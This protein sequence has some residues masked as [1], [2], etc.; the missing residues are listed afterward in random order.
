M[1]I[2]K[3]D[4]VSKS[5]GANL[6]L[7]DI[8]WQVSAND[9]VGLIGNNGTGKTTLFKIMTGE[10]S[11]YKGTVERTKRA[12]VGYLS[13][14][15]E[16]DS[17]MKLR[18]AVRMAAFEHMHD[19]E[20]RMELLTQR[21]GDPEEEDQTAILDQ[22]ARLQERH[23][24]YGG[25]NYEHRMDS[26]LGGLGF[27]QADFQL[28]VG[29]LSGGQRGRAALAHLLLLEPD[30][31]LLDEPTNH[32]D[33]AGTEWL[34]GFIASEYKGAVVVVSHDRYF[35]DKVVTKVVELQNHRLEEYGGNYTKYLF[36]K[37]RKL[38][39]QQR[40]YVRQQEEIA[41]DEEFI[42]RY[43]AGQRTKEARGREKKLARMELVEKPQLQTKKIKLE[44]TTE[45]RG[46]DDVLQ[47]MNVEKRYGDKVLFNNMKLEVYRHDRVGI[48]GPNGVG[49]TTLLRLILGQEEPTAGTVKVGYN[50]RVGYYDQEHAGL[51]LD[52][53][54]LD[55]LWELRPNDTQGE[56]R[57]YL[58]RFL[59]SG[60]DVF[61]PIRELSG[62]EQSRI[63]LSKL[64]LEKA[65]FLILDEPTNH[66]DI[67]SKEVLE[68]SL[69]EY[70]ATSIIVSH[71]RYFLDKIV[72]KI[73]FMEE[74]RTWLWEGNYTAYQEWKQEKKAAAEAEAAAERKRIA[75]EKKR[76]ET[77]ERR[78]ASGS[79]KKKK[80]K[81][82]PPKRWIGA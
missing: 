15:P 58:G 56:V 18:D 2:V 4:H 66:L 7:D 54:V 51:N 27:A 50:L 61:R 76:R 62:G 47:L 32:L 24:T 12:I 9:R 14:E 16:F 64:L 29:V 52:N 34:E 42:R 31:L 26:V 33:L 81:K 5:Y 48:I 65:N 37:E 39:V 22:Y 78:R 57:S 55:E 21:M 70:P 69:L 30:L 45:L 13:Q 44:F 35:L 19:L 75:E 71:D 28:P 41:H 67:S 68:E 11:R 1:P 3:L 43:K 38:L 73:F 59:F 46:G 79:G 10:I 63:A 36:L 49:K 8:C 53:S 60:D 80:K 82:K 23:E 74:D 40:Q 20:E 72:N 6:V 17:D 25:Y 77:D